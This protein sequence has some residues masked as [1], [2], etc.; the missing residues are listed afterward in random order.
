MNARYTGILEYLPLCIREIM[1]QTLETVGDNLL[2]IRVRCGMPLIVCTSHGNFAVCSD[3][4]ISPAIGGAYIVSETDVKQIFQAVCENSV[5]AFTD[6]IKQGFVT[7][8]GGHRVGLTG[9]AVTDGKTVENFREISSLNIRIAREVIG[10]ANSI[11]NSILK[12]DKVINTLIVSPPMGGK[13]T[14]LRD[15]SRQISNYGIKTAIV[16]DR[17]EIAAVHH[18]VPQND[19]GVQTDVIENAPKSQGVIMMLRSMSPQLI[20]TDEISTAQD[21]DA[22][23]QC[24][25]TGVAVIASTHGTSV[26]E[27]MQRKNI[28]PLLGNIG[29]RQV[30][31]LHKEGTGMNTSIWGTVTEV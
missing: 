16:D 31:V 9:R 1:K 18:G 17:G 25:G 2:E 29:F 5:Y 21:A 6:A 24:F 30:I 22:L 26:E 13:T 7:I 28:A 12:P 11:L 3:G 15:L 4:N 20:V 27:V 23:M 19:V 8:K 14:V 10:S